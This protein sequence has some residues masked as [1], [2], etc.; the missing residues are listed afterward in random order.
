[1]TLFTSFIPRSAYFAAP[2]FG[3]RPLG[4]QPC[5]HASA[6]IQKPLFQT[7]SSRNAS[8]K[9]LTNDCWRFDQ[10]QE[11]T[12]RLLLPA[13]DFTGCREGSCSG[14]LRAKDVFG[15]GSTKHSAPCGYAVARIG[16]CLNHGRARSAGRFPVR[17]AISRCSLKMGSLYSTGSRATCC[18]SAHRAKLTS[19]WTRLML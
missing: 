6:M 14:F 11:V 2:S 17:Q 19:N 13:R 10:R 9:F 4:T 8:R 15:S 18:V 7:L 5:S 1:M 16:R 3:M 12:A